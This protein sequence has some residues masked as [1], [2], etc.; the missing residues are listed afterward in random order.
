LS[1][2]CAAISTDRALLPRL[3]M[4]PVAVVSVGASIHMRNDKRYRAIRF[5]NHSGVLMF[6]LT[7]FLL[8]RYWRGEWRPTFVDEARI[9][10]MVDEACR[11]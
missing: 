8:L 2:T 7:L 5:A 1:V 9:G 4:A 10:R 3:D 11:G 6:G